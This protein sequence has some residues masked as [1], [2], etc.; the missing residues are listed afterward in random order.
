MKIAVLF[1]MKK[2]KQSRK[3]PSY[4]NEQ[5]NY[6]HWFDR[7]WY[8]HKIMAKNKRII[9]NYVVTL[10]KRQWYYNQGKTQLRL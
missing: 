7:L 2:I 3:Y 10:R 4:W 5:E 6:A 8:R 9:K 1:I